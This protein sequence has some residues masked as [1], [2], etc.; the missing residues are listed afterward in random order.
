MWMGQE[1]YFSIFTVYVMTGLKL[2]NYIIMGRKYSRILDTEVVRSVM[3][4]S[5]GDNYIFH[6]VPV[7]RGL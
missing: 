1:Y 6:S 4:Q 5:G 3:P 7:Q 2:H